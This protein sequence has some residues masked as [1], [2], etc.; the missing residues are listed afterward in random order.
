[1][2]LKTLAIIILATP[3]CL[4]TPLRA[5]TLVKF[6]LPVLLT[7]ETSWNEFSSKQGGFAV[8]MPGTPKQE[9]GTNQDGSTEHSFS[10]TSNNS[11]FLIH[12]SDI[13]K[14]EKLT[15]EEITKLLDNAPNDFAKGANA[16]LVTAKNVSLDGYPGKEFEFILGE[17]INGKG[18]VYLVNNRLY[19]VVGMT[20]QPGNVQKFLDSFRLL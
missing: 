16:T 11:A 4:S 3:L 8:S 19:I 15:K 20:T 10:L 1:M 18:R 14:I 7:Q 6:P 17:G 13:P 5:E 12:Y 2:K 9:T